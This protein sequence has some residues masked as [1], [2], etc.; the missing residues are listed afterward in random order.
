VAVYTSGHSCVV[1]AFVRG[2]D[3]CILYVIYKMHGKYIKIAKL[4]FCNVYIKSFWSTSAISSVL[5]R[6]SVFLLHITSRKCM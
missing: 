5:T 4:L 3:Y 6:I 1:V 2:G